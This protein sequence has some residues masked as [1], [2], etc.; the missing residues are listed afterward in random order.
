MIVEQLAHILDQLGAD[1]VLWLLIV[2]S[3][4]SVAVVIERLIFLARNRVPVAELQDKL[5]DALDKS[6]ESAA[7]LL[8]GY[9]GME[10]A[11][12]AA[13]V[14]HMHRGAAA[15]EEVMSGKEQIERQRY[16]RFLSYLGS[17]GANAPF[18]GLLGTVIGIMGAFADLQLSITGNDGGPNRTEA[19]MGSISEALVA[20]A[21]G[22]LVAIPAVVAYNQLRGQVKRVRA[23]TAALATILMAHLKQTSTHTD[24]ENP[25]RTA[26]TNGDKGAA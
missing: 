14:K 9:T 8:S 2:L 1:W 19:I 16:E 22:L 7:Q 17:L 23:N 6:P 10:A 13:G 25:Q 3:V 4:L 5:S 24:P 26:D 11:V 20:T 18:I 12:V 15:A 21:V